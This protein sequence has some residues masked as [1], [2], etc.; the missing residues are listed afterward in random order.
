MI[1]PEDNPLVAAD[2]RAEPPRAH[3]W[4]PVRS[5]A[6]RHR[7]RILAHLLALAEFD[8]YLRFGHPASDEQIGRYVERLD[9]DRDELFGVFNRRLELL[10]MAHLAYLPAGDAA[11]FGV[12]VLPGARS[13][14]F[15]GR[16]FDRAT[17]QARHRNVDTMIIHALTENTAMLRIVRK[18]GAKVE[19]DGGEAQARLTLPPD[20]IT[21]KIERLLEQQAAELDYRLKAGAFGVDQMIEMLSDVR[22]GVA[23]TRHSASQ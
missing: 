19:R 23:G 8:R 17:L 16:L 14:G 4:V 9:F 10:A 20:D 1:K 22:T 11:E 18:A 21:A 5:L 13:R 7:P 12:S 15:G 6:P 2:A 3:S